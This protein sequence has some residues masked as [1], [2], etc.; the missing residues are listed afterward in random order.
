VAFFFAASS[1]AFF[2]P[3]ASAASFTAT[4][5]V[6]AAMSPVVE[7]PLDPQAPLPMP[8]LTK[9]AS[10]RERLE[11]ARRLLI[12]PG[13]APSSSS[14]AEYH[15]RRRMILHRRCGR[16]APPSP[17]PYWEPDVVPLDWSPLWIG[18]VPTSS[19]EGIATSSI[20]LT[21]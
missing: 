17:F 6:A 8:L 19:I 15:R 1:V 21:A 16:L 14:A 4:T 2:F 13:H 11:G 18:A 7:L 10:A 9:Q 5:L 20:D 3:A 12:C